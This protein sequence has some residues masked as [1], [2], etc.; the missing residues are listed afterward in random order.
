M[1]HYIVLL[2]KNSN[3]QAY[4][5][6]HHY[7]INKQK[8]DCNSIKYKPTEFGKQKQRQTRIICI[9]KC[10]WVLAHAKVW[11]KTVLLNNQ[12]R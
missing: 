11:H 3:I 2:P 9:R 5:S 10:S 1:C 8:H 4:I 7:R 12:V 6:H